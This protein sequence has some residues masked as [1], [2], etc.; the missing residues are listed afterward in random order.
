MKPKID[1]IQNFILESKDNL[2]IAS[3][4]GQKW[5]D[6]RENILSDFLIRLDVRLK[7]KLRR[8]KSRRWGQFIIDQWPGYEFWKPGW[9]DDYSVGLQCGPYGQEMTFGILRD[10]PRLRKRQ[11]CEELFEAVQQIHPSAKQMLWWEARV[12]MHWPE[13]DWRQPEVLW[14][15]HKRPKFL[16]DVAAQLL[17]M[18]IISEPI[19]DRLTRKK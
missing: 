17:E 4:I 9:G 3:I 6:V 16:E 14:Q 11:F 12:V 18:A 19:I 1:P 2:R 5:P 13:S 15:I 10:G 8:W 7:K